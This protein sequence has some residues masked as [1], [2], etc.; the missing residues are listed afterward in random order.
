MQR[1]IV[2]L[3]DELLEALDRVAERDGASR[4]AEVRSAIV[5]ALAER[6]RQ[7]DLDAVVS[8]YRERPPEDLNVSLGSLSAAWP[9]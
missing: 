4:S 9:E 2:Q 5:W 1:I 6:R 7:E 3:D 8:S